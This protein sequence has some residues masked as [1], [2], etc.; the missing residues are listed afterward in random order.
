MLYLIGSIVLTSYLTLSFKVCERLKIN[1]FQ[2][3]VFNYITCVV[4]G[5]FVNGSFPVNAEAISAPWFKWACIMGTLFIVLFNIIGFT[6]QKIGV[7]VASVANKLSLVI[8][9]IFSVWLYNETATFLKIAGI[10]VALAAV[11]LTCWPS[12]AQKNTAGHAQGRML[13]LIPVIL[14]IGSGLLDTLLKYVEQGYLNDGNKNAYLISSFCFAAVLG[15]LILLI[16]VMRGKQTLAWKSVLA[17]I[18]IGFPNYF[19]IWCL[20]KVLK[21]SELQSSAIIPVN[22]MGVVLF[23]AVV[24]WFLFKEKLSGKNWMGILLSLIAIALIAFGD[25]VGG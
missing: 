7:A 21:E 14:F 10:A 13:W 17:G 8:P 19:S 9:F 22:N 15:L 25:K 24:A 3:I 4:T 2:A 20:V 1:T 5:S 12:A 16:Q 11:L 6:A 23:S 18:A